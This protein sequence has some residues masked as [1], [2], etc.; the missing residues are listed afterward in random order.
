RSFRRCLI[1]RSPALVVST[2]E[3]SLRR[4]R[5][6]RCAPGRRSLSALPASGG[7]CREG[8]RRGAQATRVGYVIWPLQRMVI[9]HRCNP[10]LLRAAGQAL[11]PHAHE[12]AKG[13]LHA[14]ADSRRNE[15][16]PVPVPL[17]LLSEAVLLLLVL[18]GPRRG[19]PK[20]AETLQL[21]QLLAEGRTK[22]G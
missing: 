19:R 4:K 18:P 10:R 16:N 14:A 13:L 1:M 22:R 15:G 2:C 11:K 17:N 9:E 21:Q 8:R 20:K 3:P 6:L 12:I 5:P 7:P